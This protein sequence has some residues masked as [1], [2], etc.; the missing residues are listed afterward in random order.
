MPRDFRFYELTDEQFEWLVV[1][2][3]SRLFGDGVISF[4]AGKDGGRDA[5]F[6]GT[7]IA[8]PSRTNPIIGH[9]VLQAKHTTTPHAS[10]SD[11]DFA[12]ELRGEYEKIKRLHEEGICDHYF[13][14]TNRR[15]DRRRR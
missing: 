7:A 4:T 1:R 5:R 11:R 15:L 14:F 2:I 3:G 6:Q 12:R 10:C 13:A 9:F 8:Y